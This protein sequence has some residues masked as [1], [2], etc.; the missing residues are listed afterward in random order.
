MGHPP[1]PTT[2]IF[3]PKLSLVPKLLLMWFW[4]V[5]KIRKWVDAFI[6]EGCEDVI[7]NWYSNIC[8]S[9][10]YMGRWSFSVCLSRVLKTFRFPKS[11]SWCQSRNAAWGLFSMLFLRVASM[12][13]EIDISNIWDW[14]FRMQI[15]DALCVLLTFHLSQLGGACF[16]RRKHQ[17]SS[18]H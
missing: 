9:G 12:S 14:V 11:G 2:P 16:W 6:F 10:A 7:G 15:G 1:P 18:K 3:L 5:V 17:N 4:R 8:V 13:L